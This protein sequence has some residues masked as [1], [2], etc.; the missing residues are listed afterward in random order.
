LADSEIFCHVGMYFCHY[1][2]RILPK[3][4]FGWLGKIIESK[5]IIP[6][7]V[8]TIIKEKIN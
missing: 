1:A 3:T 2:T 7:G 6:K 8:E 5:C 4:E